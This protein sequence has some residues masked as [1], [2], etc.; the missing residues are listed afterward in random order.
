MAKIEIFHN[1]HRDAAF[2]GFKAGRALL[3]KVFE[4]EI[5]AD[6]EWRDPRQEGRDVSFEELQASLENKKLRVES[7]LNTV[8][9]QLNVGGTELLEATEW[10]EDYR[11]A[12]NRSLSIGDVVIVD[13]SVYTVER[14][15]FDTN[16]T[17][18]VRFGVRRY[19]KEMAPI[20]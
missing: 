13:G 17:A 16:M 12:G 1:E 19:E 18:A 20:V 6:L 3:H 15:G 5:E 11:A 8:Y 4:F 2:E 9:E 7:V 14:F 10:T